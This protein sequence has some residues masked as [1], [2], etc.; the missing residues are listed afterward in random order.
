LLQVESIKQRIEKDHG[1]TVASQKLIYSGTLQQLEY[2]N[3]FIASLG[4][5]LEDSKI[6]EHYQ[7][8]EGDFLV[9][10]VTKVRWH[11]RWIKPSCY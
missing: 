6:L 9:L 4:K 1:H 10:M 2:L 8:K 7:M 5:I 11:K 3:L